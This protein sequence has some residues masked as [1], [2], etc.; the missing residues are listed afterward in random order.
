MILYLHGFRSGP[1]SQKVQALALRMAQRGLGDYLWCEQLS[2]VPCEAIAQAEAQLAR[3]TTPPLLAG[4]SLGGF[5]ATHLAE[6]H[7]LQAVVINPFVPHAG[8][9][10]SL[11]IGEHQ[12]IYSGERFSFTA[13]HAAQIAALDVA[14]I[15]R[16]ENFWLLAE[17]GDEVL[18]YRH[19]LKRYAGCHQSVLPG[20]D[21]SFTRWD[22]YL[23]AVIERA[24]LAA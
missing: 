8:F 10:Q 18:D 16:P 6:K 17:E 3:C 20:G 11:F 4:S 23:D 21:H 7:A 9:D 12:M 2:P 13:E 15:S 5:Y 19:A 22:D 1:Q 14:R 24:G